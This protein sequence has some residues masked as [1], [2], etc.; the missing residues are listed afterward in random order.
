MSNWL[1]SN[2]VFT[3]CGL[4]VTDS[5]TCLKACTGL[6]DIG[7][8]IVVAGVEGKLVGGAVQD[9]KALELFALKACEA[10]HE[11]GIEPVV[12]K[13]VALLLQQA[14]LEAQH[15]AVLPE[16]EGADQLVDIDACTIGTDIGKAL[17][18][19][20]VE[21]KSLGIVA[22]VLYGI[23]AVVAGLDLYFGQHGNGYFQRQV[24]LV[25]VH[26]LLHREL[27]GRLLEVGKPNGIAFVHF[28]YVGA[29]AVGNGKPAAGAQY[30]NRF[31][32]VGAG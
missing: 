30:R 11:Q 23:E 1:V 29:F 28:N 10:A 25:Q 8:E 14:L 18:V 9:H 12:Y 15:G 6:L 21:L 2:K 7:L 31:K 27:Y 19:G 20:L 4:H 22:P 26:H 5:G 17:Y 24:K 32:G 13:L 3:D 16:L